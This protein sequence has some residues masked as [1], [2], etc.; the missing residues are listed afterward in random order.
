MK[1]EMSF[2][3][4]KHTPL[5]FFYFITAQCISSKHKMIEKCRFQCIDSKRFIT[6]SDSLHLMGN[7][8][9]LYLCISRAYSPTS[10]SLSSLHVLCLCVWGRC[11]A[12]SCGRR[13]IT[14]LGG[15]G[16]GSGRA[17][18]G[19]PAVSSSPRPTLPIWSPSSQFLSFHTA[20][21]P[22]TNLLLRATGE[23]RWAPRW[24]ICGVV[25]AVL[26]DLIFSYEYIDSVWL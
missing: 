3:C 24:H 7:F 10:M 12:A 22:S 2:Y 11:W 4:F 21:R 26:R 13:W 14:V 19:W 20:S 5:S 1:F 15:G 23:S 8:S 16:R 17:G 18:G 25:T 6:I 9:P